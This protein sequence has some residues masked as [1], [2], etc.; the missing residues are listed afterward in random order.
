MHVYYKNHIIL[1]NYSLFTIFQCK[2]KIFTNLSIVNLHK[3]RSIYLVFQPF[4]PLTLIIFCQLQ[5]LKKIII[6]YNEN[7]VIAKINVVVITFSNINKNLCLKTRPSSRK[8][9]RGNTIQNVL[10]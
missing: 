4:L 5:V 6:R 2:I 10:I 3:S 8:R 1:C 7:F 9:C